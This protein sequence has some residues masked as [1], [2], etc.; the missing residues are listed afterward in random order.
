MPK[1]FSGEAF[2]ALFQKFPVAKKFM[3]KR[4][5]LSSFSVESFLSNSAENLRRE[6]FTVA[7][8]S[9]TEKVWGRGGV[10]RFYVDNFLSHSAEIFRRGILYCCINFR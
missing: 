4:G 7:S 1:I 9:G 10:T 2:Y 6:S 5:G 3:D 8:I